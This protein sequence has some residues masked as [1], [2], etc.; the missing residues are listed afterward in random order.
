MN[1]NEII[2]R[3]T[4]VSGLKMN[5]VSRYLPL[6]ADC[7]ELFLERASGELSEARQRRL[8]HACA[9]YAYYRVCLLLRDGGL[10]SFKAGDVQ[11][12]TAKFAELCDG[13]QR[14]WEEERTVISDIVSF[15]EGFA[16]RSVSV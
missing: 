12:N 9:V 2:E 5:E 13:A 1:L 10:E 16:F 11:M 15:D 14:M 4:L 3:F 7:R 6:I 8:A